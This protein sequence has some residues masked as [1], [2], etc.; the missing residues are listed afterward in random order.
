[1]RLDTEILVLVKRQA[2]LSGVILSGN[3]SGN[4]LVQQVFRTLTFCVS[5]PDLYTLNV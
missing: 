4:E 1:M 5:Y 3:K 2:P